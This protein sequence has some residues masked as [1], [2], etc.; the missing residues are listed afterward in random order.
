MV[1]RSPASEEIY[2]QR[3]ASGDEFRVIHAAEFEEKFWLFIK[4]AAHTVQHCG[5]MFAHFGGI[6]AGAFHFDLAGLGEQAVGV[7]G[8]GLHDGIG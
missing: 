8:D 1:L 4:P 6:G 2:W 3:V 5:E 7:T